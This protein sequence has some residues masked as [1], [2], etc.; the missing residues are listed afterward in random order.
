MSN[1]LEHA[2]LEVRPGQIAEFETALAQAI[3]LIAATPGFL[4]ISVRPCVERPSRY[5][6]LVRWETVAA[7]EVG[8]RQ[9][10]RYERWKELLHRFY[11]PAPTVEHYG[12][13]IVTETGS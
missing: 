6:L 1:I 10:D 13:P 9:S 7:H 12:P 8:F 11:D 2:I 5:L 4:G 3:P